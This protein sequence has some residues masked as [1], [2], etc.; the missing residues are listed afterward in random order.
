MVRAVFVTSDASGRAVA[1]A[2]A[3]RDEAAA[4]GVHLPMLRYDRRLGFSA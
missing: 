3:V 2:R 4:N 1:L